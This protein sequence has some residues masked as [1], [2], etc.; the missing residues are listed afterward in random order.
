MNGS[1][2]TRRA[3]LAGATAAGAALLAACGG[4]A[5]TAGGS[6]KSPVEGVKATGTI[7]WSFWAVSQEQADNMLARVSD[8]N[9]T[10]PDVKVEALWVLNGDYRAKII[11]LISAGT[12]PDCTQV[13]AYD[14]P[15]FVAQ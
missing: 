4:A 8:F 2:L 6:E 13:D 1:A 5:G 14:M 12:P 15:A 3:M 9:K 11:S 7:N 10:H